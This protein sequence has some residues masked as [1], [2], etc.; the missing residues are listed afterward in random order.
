L[1]VDDKIDSQFPPFCDDLVQFDVEECQDL[2]KVLEKL[3]MMVVPFQ[4][5]KRVVSQKLC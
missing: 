3:K 5:R 1:F 2:T 4:D